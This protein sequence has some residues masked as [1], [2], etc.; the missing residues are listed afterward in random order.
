MSFLGPIAGIATR[1]LG[2][3][4]LAAFALGRSSG[5]GESKESQPA[6]ETPSMSDITAP[7]NPG[8]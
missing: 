1:V 2:G 7:I 3:G 6:Q 5:S 4:R 8:R